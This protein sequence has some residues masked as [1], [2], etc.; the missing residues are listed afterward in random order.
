M[1]HV[2]QGFYS[3]LAHLEKKIVFI[4]SRTSEKFK[5]HSETLFKLSA[6]TAK[7]EGTSTNNSSKEIRNIFKFK[8]CIKKFHNFESMYLAMF[9]WFWKCQISETLVFEQL[10]VITG[11]CGCTSICYLYISKSHLKK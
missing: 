8:T 10:A 11:A 6:L 9:F 7:I 2:K 3:E 4:V 1:N 5:L